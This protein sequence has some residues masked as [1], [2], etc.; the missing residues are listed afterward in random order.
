MPETMSLERQNLLKAMGAELVLT[1]GNE[2]MSGAIRKQKNFATTHQEQS[3]CSNLKIQ[4][5]LEPIL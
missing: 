3:F 5:T 1:P 4:Q 2:E